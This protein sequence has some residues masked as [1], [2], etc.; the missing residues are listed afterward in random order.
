MYEWNRII[1]VGVAYSVCLKDTKHMKHLNQWC[2]DLSRNAATFSNVKRKPGFI[3][4]EYC[5]IF[6]HT[7]VDLNF[8]FWRYYL[9]SLNMF[10]GQAVMEASQQCHAVLQL[11]TS[12]FSLISTVYNAAELN[13]QLESN[14]PFQNLVVSNLIT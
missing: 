11:M 6:P 14:S 9:S 10:Q 5:I 8:F 7:L 4:G 3:L 12:T 2:D 13:Q 1:C